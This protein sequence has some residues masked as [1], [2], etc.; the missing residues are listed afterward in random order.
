MFAKMLVTVSKKFNII[1]DLWCRAATNGHFLLPINLLI[2][3]SINR[4]VVR[5]LTHQKMVLIDVS[6]SPKVTSSDVSFDVQLKLE[7]VDL[8]FLRNNSND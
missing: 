4:S 2:V 6:Q 8:F 7:N 3:L 1:A 5:S